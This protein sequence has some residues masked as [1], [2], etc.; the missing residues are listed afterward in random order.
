M[1][2]RKRIC[3]GDDQRFGAIEEF[4]DFARGDSIVI[5]LAQHTHFIIAQNSER[6]LRRNEIALLPVPSKTSSRRPRK[7]K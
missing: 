7:M 6:L 5:I 1:H 2:R 4:R 3:L